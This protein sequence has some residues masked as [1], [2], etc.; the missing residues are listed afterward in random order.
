VKSTL[1][2]AYILLFVHFGLVP[3]DLFIEAMQLKPY[4]YAPIAGPLFFPHIAIGYSFFILAIINLIKGYKKATTGHKRTQL[5]YII[6]GISISIILANFD[7]L[8]LF[9]LPLYPGA[10]IGNTLFVLI[11]SIAIVK[12]QLLDINIII[13]KGLAYGLISALVFGIYITI[14]SLILLTPLNNISPLL[15][16]II[17]ILLAIIFHPL[18]ERAQKL[19][20]KLFYRDRYDH[21][22]ALEKFGRGTKGISELK[23]LADS[24]INMV[25]QAMHCTK[26]CLMVFDHN[27]KKF[28]SAASYGF[29]QNVHQVLPGNTTLTRWLSH[30]DEI[31]EWDRIEI[32]PQLQSITTKEKNLLDFMHAQ[33]LV[34]LKT[35]KGLAGT[36]ILGPKQSND[37]YTEDDIR[38]LTIAG[39]QLA[40][41]LDNARLY[42]ES[43]RSYNE[44][45]SVQERLVFSAKLKALGEMTS[46]IAHDFNNVLTTILGTAQLSLVRI[47]KGDKNKDKMVSDLETIEQATLDAAQMVRRLQDFARVRTDRPLTSVALNKVIKNAITMI[48]PRIDERCQTMDAR[49]NIILNLNEIRPV[50]G[51][52]SELR[53]TLVNILINAIDAMPKGGN[54]T[55]QSEQK[56]GQSVILISDDGVGMPGKVKKKLFEPFFTT[57]GS[58]GLGMGLS[59][60]YGIVTRHKGQIEVESEPG[61]GSTFTISLPSVTK[62][63]E[64]KVSKSMQTV[65]RSY[66]ILVIDDDEGPRRVLEEILSESGYNVERAGSGKDGLSL[67]QQKDYD[68]VVTD[69]GM[70]DIPGK[71]VARI[72]KTAN[73]ET[74]VIL[75]TGWGIQLD[76]TE[77]KRL[78]IDGIVTKPFDRENIIATINRLLDTK[79]ESGEPLRKKQPV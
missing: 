20:D 28:H 71:D 66:D 15:S 6:I 60:V 76:E 9:G 3:T 25:S 19:I 24:M 34:P 43:V 45:K 70:P 61:K 41:A 10:V 52:E 11:A 57:K 5:S 47:K 14:V 54:I 13:R 77:L 16:G 36:L 17:I 4:G 2:A 18:L 67:T 79:R 35:D 55:I 58:S 46:G 40:I 8:P 30:H 22:I 48:Q 12:H 63:K 69:V 53:E 59:V 42:E 26:S 32:E 27:K 50:K 49:T 62:D 64:Q 29:D 68:L 44:L 51:S 21:L 56:D 73:P 39:R 75:C 1:I 37:I 72:I 33:L 38:L 78:G 7:F 31:L 65:M 23:S 74:K